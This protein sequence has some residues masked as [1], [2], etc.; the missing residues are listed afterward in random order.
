[1][2]ADQ[3]HDYD[4]LTRST[5]DSGNYANLSD[6]Y[7]EKDRKYL[8]DSFS[9]SFEDPSAWLDK[10]PPTVLDT[11]DTISRRSSLSV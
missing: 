2:A 11:N 9:E 1:M 10:H 7:A 4:T 8:D 3:D 5:E 6:A